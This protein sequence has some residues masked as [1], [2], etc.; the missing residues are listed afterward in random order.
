[1]TRGSPAQCVVQS[2]DADRAAA[3]LSSVRDHDLPPA[4]HDL[5]AEYQSFDGAR[6]WFIW[7]WVHRLAPKNTM[8]AVDAEH[9]ETVA[10]NKTI[11]VLFIT[12]LDDLVEKRRDY[13]T[14]DAIV[15]LIRLNGGGATSGTGPGTQSPGAADNQSLGV[16][17]NPSFDARYGPSVDEAYVDFARTVWETLCGR[18]ERSPSYERYAP[19]FRFDARQIVTAIEYS[20]LAIDRPDLAT[21]ADLRRYETHNM[22]MYSYLD[23]DL[24]YATADYTGD[25]EAL[26]SVVDPAQRMARIG[27]W[28]STWERE[29]R[30]GD[31]SSGVAVAA[32]ERGLIEPAEVQDRCDLRDGDHSEAVDRAIERIRASGLEAEFLEEW[33]EEYRRLVSLSHRTDVVDLDPFVE[34]TKDVLRYHLASRGFK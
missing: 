20:T 23:I 29:L 12:I 4:L 33:D 1:M 27:N 13:E 16:T 21:E 25:L 19:L 8:P 2:L 34:G 7:R 22:G 10:T 14:F 26:R 6:P 5:V 31:V 17:D 18:L 9:R 24:M 11:L 28:L 15:R 30:E 32:I 3:L